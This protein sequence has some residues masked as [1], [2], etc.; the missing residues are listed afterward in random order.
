MAKGESKF[1]MKAIDKKK[2]TFQP[3]P[4]ADYDLKL[5]GDTVEIKKADPSEKNPKPISYVNV[6]F[7][8]LKSAKEGGRNQRVY[9]RLF[10][11][12]KPGKDGMISPQLADGL[13]GLGDALGSLPSLDTVTVEATDG[14]TEMVSPLA[15]KKWLM[16]KD[17]EVV[18]GHVKIKAGS[19]GYADSNVIAEFFEADGEESDEEGEDEESEDEEEKPAKKGKLKA[20]EEDEEDDE[21]DEDEDEDEDEDDDLAAAV[22]GK[23]GKKSK[24]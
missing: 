16:G 7:E 5:L 15:V 13:K 10:L 6:A 17:G 9:H 4:A 20:V 1:D 2:R 12:L 14:E 23:K 18:R 22:K 3:I 8:A 19:K 21:T 24:K 11:S